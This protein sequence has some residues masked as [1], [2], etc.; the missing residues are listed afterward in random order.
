MNKHSN[1]SIVL[2]VFEQKKNTILAI[3]LENEI[4]K[5]N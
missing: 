4:P 1:K 2:N 3:E 5:K